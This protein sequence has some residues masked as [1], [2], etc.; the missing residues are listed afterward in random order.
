MKMSWWGY[1]II[2]AMQIVLVMMFISP[3][4]IKEEVATE[5]KKTEWWLGVQNTAELYKKS[6]FDYKHSFVETG[7]EDFVFDT[8]VLHKQET[9]DK[10]MARAQKEPL[11]KVIEDRLT[12]LFFI[13]QTMFFRARLFL[14]TFFL[15]L[16]YLIPVMIDG[17]MAREILKLSEDNASVTM[18]S[19]SK[20]TLAFLVFLPFLMMF[21]PWA[22]S[23]MWLLIWA[24]I[25]SMNVWQVAKNFQ[26]RL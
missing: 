8:F 26:H 18:Y 22:I 15:T 13:I 7:I 1:I 21:W 9:D 5:Y 23:P 25:F 6:T 14:M 4:H 12:A 19:I 20:Y 3:D 11:W 16:P 24:I 2:W 10:A 17:L